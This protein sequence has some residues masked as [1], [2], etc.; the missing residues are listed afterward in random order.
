VVTVAAA[1]LLLPHQARAQ[2]VDGAV[3]AVA[4]SNSEVDRTRQARGFGAGAMV[5]VT[6]GRFRV[7]LRGVTSSLHAD[8]AIQPD[9]ALDE[10]S[11]L[12]SYRWYPALSV[13]LGAGRRFTRPDFAA[14]DVGV[15]RVGLLTEAPLTSLARVQARAAYLPLTHFSGGG[16]SS[17]ALELGF[18]LSLGPSAGRY[19]G[20]LEFEYQRIDRKVNGQ[21]VPIRS[22]VARLGLTRRW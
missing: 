18:G 20:V 6:R 16:S 10:L 22:S 15:L 2:V 9:Y 12:G 8:F 17:L 3:Y 14:Q 1:V 4:A 7:E 5:G 19:A 13:Q 21:A 11:V